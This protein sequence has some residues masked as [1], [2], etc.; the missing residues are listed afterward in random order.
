MI[1][2]TLWVRPFN[3]HT[4]LF[5]TIIR[6]CLIENTGKTL[7]KSEPYFLNLISQGEYLLLETDDDTILN[8]LE[9]WNFRNY[10]GFAVLECGLK[11][12]RNSR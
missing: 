5:T 12:N 3:V 1:N 2:K 9:F 8:H 7:K 4:I 11:I 10:F 6:L